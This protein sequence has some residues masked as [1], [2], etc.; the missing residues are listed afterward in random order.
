M[1]ILSS[2]SGYVHK[3]AAIC[4]HMAAQCAY[5]WLPQLKNKSITPLWAME[6]VELANPLSTV[7]QQ[8]EEL[9]VGGAMSGI[10]GDLDD[11]DLDEMEIDDEDNDDY[12]D[13]LA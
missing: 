12:L 2:V 1:S 6:F 9:D 13:S 5:Y 8:G 3:Q 11:I 4:E 7:V 10:E